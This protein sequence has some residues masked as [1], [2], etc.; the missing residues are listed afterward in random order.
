MQDTQCVKDLLGQFR[1]KD[2]QKN[3]HHGLSSDK[4]NVRVVTEESD[5]YFHINVTLWKGLTWEDTARNS[6]FNELKGGK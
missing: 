5:N 1:L 6:F 2:W 3:K 4:Q